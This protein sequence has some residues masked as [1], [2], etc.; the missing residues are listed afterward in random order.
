MSEQKV[1]PFLTY[2]MVL[3]WLQWGE[4]PERLDKPSMAQIA[5]S[6]IQEYRA[7]IKNLEQE[8]DEYRA[9]LEAVRSQMCWERDRDQLTMGFKDLH[10]DVTKVLGRGE[11]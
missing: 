10:D 2:P 7:A 8:R 1:R 4:F 11:T 6:L 5:L 9:A 3:D